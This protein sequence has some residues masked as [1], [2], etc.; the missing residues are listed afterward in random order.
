MIILIAYV[1]NNNHKDSNNN[2]S[3]NNNNN[4]KKLQTLETVKSK[5][6]P[7]TLTEIKYANLPTNN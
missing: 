5:R 7:D 6:T 1:K 3:D 4:K 2:N